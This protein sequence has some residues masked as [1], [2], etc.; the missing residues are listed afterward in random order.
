MS[1]TQEDL[2]VSLLLVQGGQFR[3][4]KNSRPYRYFSQTYSGN[5]HH[6]VLNVSGTIKKILIVVT[7]FLQNWTSRTFKTRICQISQ[8][9]RTYLTLEKKISRP[10]CHLVCMLVPSCFLDIHCL[11]FTCCNCVPKR[12]R[13]FTTEADSVWLKFLLKAVDHNHDKV[14]TTINSMQSSDDHATAPTALS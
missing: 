3:W 1:W 9:S 2:T 7:T 6:I 13:H 5:I 4:E 10:Y 11:V 8:L 12:C 14:L